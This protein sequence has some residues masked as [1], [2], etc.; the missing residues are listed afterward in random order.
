VKIIRVHLTLLTQQASYW[1][2]CFNH[3]YE[4]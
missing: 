2:G 1:S 3:R 4:V